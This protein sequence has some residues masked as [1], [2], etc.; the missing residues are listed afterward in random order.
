M[1][2]LRPVARFRQT[3]CMQLPALE[4]MLFRPDEKVFVINPQKSQPALSNVAK[5][6]D[7]AD[8]VMLWATRE[9]HLPKYH[10]R[11]NEVL[12]EA[13]LWVC[14]PKLGRLATDLGRDKL[15][16]WMKHHGFEGVR[17]V[18]VDDTWAAASFR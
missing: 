17:L 11:L 13:V 3:R 5:A 15:W 14:Y 18:S 8:S 4:K 12:P 1:H 9:A 16:M 6:I 2:F 10:A 7:L